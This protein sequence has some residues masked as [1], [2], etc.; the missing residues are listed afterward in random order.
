VVVESPTPF[1]RF[2]WTVLFDLVFE[3]YQGL[4]EPLWWLRG[5]R[6]AGQSEDERLAWAE[7]AIREL[8]RD[9]LIYFFRV[10]PSGEIN[11][12]GVDP[13]L[14]LSE[15]ELDATVGSDWW[16]APLG[17]NLP[18]GHPN[19]WIGPTPEGEAAANDPPDAIRRLYPL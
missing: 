13:N 9:G 4:W 2:K 1:E 14:R 3:D 19:I 8:H 15:V 7:R 6:D 5:S 12:S 16:R 17:Q 11:E 18:A 10:P